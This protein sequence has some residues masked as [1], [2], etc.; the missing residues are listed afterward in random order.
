VAGTRPALAEWTED[1]PANLSRFSLQEIQFEGEFDA[2]EGELRKAIRSSTSGILRFRPVD[3]DRIEGDVIRL[4][5]HLRRKGYWNAEVDRRITF[6]HERR[7][8][9]VVFTIKSGAQRK[10]GKIRVEGQRSFSESEILAWTKLREGEPFDISLASN[11]RTAIESAYANRGFYQVEVTA[12]IQ[13]ASSDSPAGGPIVHD[14]VH[15]VNE[16]LRFIVGKIDI[17]GNKFT[18]AEIIRRELKIETGKVLNRDELA[19]SRARLY[20]TG[21]FSNVQVLPRTVSATQQ[22]MD[23]VVRVVERKMR[24][25]GLGVGYGTQDQLR[26]SGEWGHRNLFGHGKRATIRG[27][28]AT[29]LPADLVRTRFEGRYV[30]PWLFDTRATGAGEV[31]FE[32][33]REFIG[34]EQ[35]QASAD[36]ASAVSE[37]DLNLVGLVTN[38]NRDLTRYT[39]AWVA[40][41]NEWADADAGFIPP[42]DLRLAPA[43]TRTISIGVERDRR[44]DYFEPENGFLNRIIGSVSGGV[45]GGDN[46]FW[47]VVGEMNWYRMAAG[48]VWAGRLRVGQAKPFG[49]TDIIVNHERFKLGGANTVRGYSEREQDLTIGPGDFMILGNVEARFP[50]FWILRGGLFLDGGNAWQSPSDVSL[51][52]FRIAASRDDPDLARE[53]D[54]RYSTGAGIRFATPVGPVRFDAARKIKR[55]QAGEDLWDFHLSLGHVF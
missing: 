44:D 8:T 51:K 38:I 17:E 33:T 28:L 34:L 29:E 39:R 45:L 43:V 25:V 36:T 32:R 9:R 48:I 52:D 19:E 21:Y 49:K 4:R 23:I 12:D 54:F 1:R 40:L 11:D 7:R 16:G 24:F 10:A 55:V 5:N 3:L 27:I 31:Y 35:E 15:R 50:L 53:R 42:E 46:D 47:R 22:S 14:L 37:Y 13:A 2:T 20:S 41:E 30:E 18:D 6:D 26:L